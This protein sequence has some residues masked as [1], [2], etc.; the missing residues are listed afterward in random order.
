MEKYLK[1]IDDSIKF[2]NV[3]NL[4]SNMIVKKYKIINNI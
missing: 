3:I 2:I 1:L 4:Y